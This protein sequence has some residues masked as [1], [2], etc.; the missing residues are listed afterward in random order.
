MG[1]T[2]LPNLEA[3]PCLEVGPCVES[4]FETFIATQQIWGQA[5][6]RQSVLHKG[7]EGQGVDGGQGA[8]MC[9]LR[10][11]TSTNSFIIS[12]EYSVKRVL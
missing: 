5:V 7:Y 10:N 12:N 1:P 9:A 8:K 4:S 11:S 2:L 6:F 3:R